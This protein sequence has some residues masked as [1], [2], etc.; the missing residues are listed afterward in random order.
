MGAP[1]SAL[2][3]EKE[4]ETRLYRHLLEKYASLIDEKE[5]KTVGEIKALVSRDDLTI[6]IFAEKFMPKP[7][8]F[9]ENYPEAAEKALA[10]IQENIM[11]VRTG[12]SFNYWLSPKEILELKTCED[13]DLSIFFCSVLYSLGDAKAKVAIAE[14][15]NETTKSFVTTD[16]NGIYYILDP[17]QKHGFSEFSGKLN[18]AIAKYSYNGF[19]IEKFMYSFNSQEYKEFI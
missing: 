13:E 15:K 9:A 10:Y 5:K 3:M 2:F 8:S 7:Y 14:M 1:Q 17:A 18:E 6:Q 19:S 12:L 4:T 16:F 11:T